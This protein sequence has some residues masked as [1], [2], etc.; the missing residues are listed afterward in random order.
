M[1]E[2]VIILTTPIPIDAGGLTGSYVHVKVDNMRRSDRRRSYRA[3]IHYGNVIGGNFIEGAVPPPAAYPQG[4]SVAGNP[5]YVNLITAESTASGQRWG[6]LELEAV[7]QYL[8]DNR[9]LDGSIATV[10]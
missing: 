8:L 1:P 2:R 5:D 7:Y 10:S 4:F 6:R 3:S 9:I